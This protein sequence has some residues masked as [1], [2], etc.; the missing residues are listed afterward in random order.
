MIRFG[1]RFDVEVRTSVETADAVLAK[2][3]FALFAC[4]PAALE[5][6][7]DFAIAIKRTDFA[8]RAE[9]RIPNGSWECAFGMDAEVAECDYVPTGTTATDGTSSA[10]DSPTRS[11]TSKRPMLGFGRSGPGTKRRCPGGPIR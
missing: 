3:A 4:R 11:T 5:D 2:T 6:Q 1:K 7:A 8:W 9:R 10:G